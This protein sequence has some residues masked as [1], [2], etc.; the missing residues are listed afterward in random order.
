MAVVTDHLNGFGCCLRLKK[1]S[2][3]S[4]VTDD[5]P[6]ILHGPANQDR[7]LSL[8]VADG[9]VDEPG[10]LLGQE[11]DQAALGAQSNM[12]SRALSVLNHRN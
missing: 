3:G 7:G 1:L 6:H 8:V 9:G 12:G 4:K 5:G 2:T 11:F 10:A